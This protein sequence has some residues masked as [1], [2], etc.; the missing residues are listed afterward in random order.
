[1]FKLTIIKLSFLEREQSKSNETKSK[2]DCSYQG[3][4]L[5]VPT[6]F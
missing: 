5:S 1:M 3:E 6:A 4:A 2:Q